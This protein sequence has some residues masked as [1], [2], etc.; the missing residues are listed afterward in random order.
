MSKPGTTSI[1]T[2]M[3]EH[4]DKTFAGG[5]LA[6]ADDVRR[7]LGSLDDEKVVAIMELRPTLRDVEEA[8]LWLAGDTD[9]FG[10][11]P[12]KSIAG[13]IVDVLTDEDE[14]PKAPA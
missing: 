4:T 8:S 10:A 7:I 13:S 9:V 6:S 11:D 2:T 12:L 1:R 14:E 3:S 5:P